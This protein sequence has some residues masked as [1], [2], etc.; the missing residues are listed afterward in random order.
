[1]P[2]EDLVV[3][4]DVGTSQTKAALVGPSGIVAF[5]KQDYPG[6][7]AYPQPGWAEQDVTYLERAILGTVRALAGNNADLLPSVRGLTFTSQMQGVLPVDRDGNPL[8]RMLTWL[9]V[10]AA[11]VAR[12]MFKGWPAYKGFSLRKMLKFIRRT[13][14]APGMTG[15]D[16]LCKIF[17]LK[18][19]EP[20]IYESAHK[21]LD[22]KDF[23]VH[24]AT[25]R[26]ATSVDMAFI[27]WLMDI[28]GGKFRWSPDILGEYD[29][30]EGKMCEI[31]P[32]TEVV[33][34][35]TPEF[36][37]TT[38]LPGG[39]DVVNG[40]GDLLTSAIGSGAI[41]TGELHANIGTAGWVGCHFPEM[42]RDIPRYTGTVASGIPGAYLIL[43]KQET[44]GG[45]LEWMKELLFPKELVGDSGNAE[46]FGKIDQL[47]G[48]TPAGAG[49][50]LFTPWLMGERSPKNNPH[51][52]GQ[53]FNLSLD[54]TRGHVLRAVFEGVAFN[55]RWGMEAVEKLS[56]SPRDSIRLIGGAAKSDVWC[57]TLADVWQKRV[58]RVRDPQQ[59][60]ARGAAVIAM[61][62]LGILP[63]FSRAASLASVE[64]VFDP[65]PGV[66]PLYDKLFAQY[67]ALYE[68]AK[69]IHEKLNA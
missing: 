42:C 1:M 26:F 61:V 15:K 34:R 49:N 8:Y 2:R 59:A 46:V 54:T 21:F 3:A 69:K 43:S 40:A 24:L 39:V 67:M 33:G 4:V 17:W 13:G 62:S 47:V 55:L 31:L 68:A 36:A 66:A 56:G 53:L 12:E 41:E 11:G 52:R 23:A 6:S 9:D 25:G 48:E 35:V 32:S 64:R 16:T 29:L 5:E 18:R 19:H 63:D 45:A 58:E 38:G 30:D 10:R 7:L 37:K 27:T 65:D 51:V 14:G 22:T 28:R 57:Q 44:L 20:R 60:S 50:V